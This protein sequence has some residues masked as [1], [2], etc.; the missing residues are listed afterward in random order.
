MCVYVGPC[1][2]KYACRSQ[3]T[4][5]Q[6]QFSPFTIGGIELRSS[7]LTTGPEPISTYLFI[8]TGVATCHTMHDFQES[9]LFHETLLGSKCL[10]ALSHLTSPSFLEE[11]KVFFILKI[12]IFML[13]VHDLP[14]CIS[15]RHITPVALIGSKRLLNRL[16]LELYYWL[17]PPCRC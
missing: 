7:N 2:S 9:D 3:K 12:T 8:F 17:L 11:N 1:V 6:S 4:T 10:Y 15:M 14:A 5:S 16:E 13:C